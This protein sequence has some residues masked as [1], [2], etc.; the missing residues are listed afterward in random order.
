M[1]TQAVATHAKAQ[2]TQHTVAPRP[3]ATKP[4]PPREAPKAPP[5]DTQRGR[6]VDKSA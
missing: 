3:V 4:E 1:T 5:A 2:P 6:H